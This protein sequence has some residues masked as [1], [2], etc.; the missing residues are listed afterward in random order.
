MTRKEMTMTQVTI[1]QAL[2]VTTMTERVPTMTTSDRRLLERKKRRLLFQQGWGNWAEY[3]QLP[4][5]MEV[6]FHYTKEEGYGLG[7]YYLNMQ[8]AW[9][10]S[11]RALEEAQRE[12]FQYVLFTHGWS[13][14][15]IGKTTARSQVRKLLRSK[16]ATPYVIRRDCIQHNSVFVAAI[17]PIAVRMEADSAD[18]QPSP[19]S[20]VL[21]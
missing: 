4:R 2:P 19:S 9:D 15:R 6:D 10:R 20:L 7:S 8:D 14:S 12:G 18:H 3:R 5:V 13:T 21:P 1:P 17:R 11:L 16:A